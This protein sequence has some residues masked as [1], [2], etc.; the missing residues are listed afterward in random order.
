MISPAGDLR[1]HMAQVLDPRGREGKRH[2]L[3]AILTAV[4]CAVRCKRL[5]THLSVAA[6][7]TR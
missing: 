4:V 7:T 6:Q 5:Q 2:P 1:Q 3:S